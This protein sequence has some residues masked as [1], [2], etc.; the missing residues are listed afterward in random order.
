MNKKL[1]FATAR[2]PN[3][4][5]KTWHIKL[6]TA[7]AGPVKLAFTYIE[8]LVVITIITL[9]SSSWVFY[10]LDFLK[11]QELSQ[12]VNTID[13]NFKD[14]DKRIKNYSIFDY[15]MQFS[16]WTWSLWYVYYIN[17]F[18]I[19][20]RQ[21]VDFDSSTWSGTLWTNWNS[22]QQW[23]FKMYKK[24]KL[25]LNTVI[26]SDLNFDF[27]FND[28]PYYKI[29]WTLSWETL[30]EININYFTEDNLY[31]INNNLL[32]LSNIN[33]KQDKSGINISNLSIKNIWWKKSIIWDWNVFDEAYLFFD[34]NW[35]EEFIRIKK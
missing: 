22:S 26:Q 13:D 17:N 34:S 25:Y 4:C 1:K 35:K 23:K 30:N 9:L 16:V 6:A 8:L 20:Y 12:K 32:I 24:I 14:L 33:T 7:K 27:S 21:F 5:G 2:N 15:E 19:P 29:I 28:E 3:F 31:P 11:N 10:F 18:D